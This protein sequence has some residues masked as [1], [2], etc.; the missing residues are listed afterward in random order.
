MTYICDQEALRKDGWRV[1]EKWILPDK[2]KALVR[3]RFDRAVEKLLALNQQVVNQIFHN[4][5]QP[6][7]AFWEGD[8]AKPHLGIRGS[9]AKLYHQWK[10]AYFDFWNH[11]TVPELANWGGEK[12]LMDALKKR[13]LAGQ[14]YLHALEVLSAPAELGFFQEEERDL[15]RIAIAHSPSQPP[16]TLRGGDRSKP[17]LKIRGGRGSYE[18]IDDKELRKALAAHARK[19]FWLYNSYYGSR[20]L[21][22]ADFAK[23]LKEE[24]KKGSISERMRAIEQAPRQRARAKEQMIKKLGFSKLEATVARKLGQTISWQDERKKYVWQANHAIDIFL[25]EVARRA[26]VPFTMCKDLMPDEIEAVL[27]GARVNVRDLAKARQVSVMHLEWEKGDSRVYTGKAA[28]K[29]LAP[30]EKRAHQGVEEVHGLTVSRGP[31]VR[32]R[33]RLIF[34]PH[35]ELQRMKH[36][37]ILVTGMTS[38][39]YIMVMKRAA[40]IVTDTG[41]MTSH[42]AVVSRELGVPCIV[43]TKVATQV[44]KDGDIVEVDAENGTVRKI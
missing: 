33:V 20:V 7:R 37:D 30:F 1:F 43:G 31:K 29:V 2:K 44:F 3:R 26:R 9:Y 16:L 22:A 12:F 32:G 25:N 35:K 24:I 13:G 21:T 38:P 17:P 19:Y 18:F 34:S 11:G 23:R 14:E 4:P 39:D 10:E 36:G 15:L 41:G 8:Q 40:A 28:L 5:P 27:S 6:S 42:A